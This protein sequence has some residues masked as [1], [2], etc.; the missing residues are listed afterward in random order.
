LHSEQYKKLRQDMESNW[1]PGCGKCKQEEE[2]GV[3][4]LRQKFN[5]K[6]DPALPK[7]KYLEVGFDNICDL[8]CDG[9]WE[10]WSSS[11]WAKKNPQLPA[12]QG[13][14]STDKFTNIPNSINRVVF[15]GGEPLMTNR[16]RKFLESLDSLESLTVEYF[17]NGMHKLQDTDIDLLSKCKQ[18]HFTVSIDAVGTLNDKVRSGSVWSKVLDTLNQIAGKFDYTIHTTVH[19]NNWHGLSD[20]HDFVKAYKKW[21]INVLTFPRGMDI[22]NLDQ[23][24]KSKFLDMLEKFDIP[25][26]HYIKSHLEGVL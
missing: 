14:T 22:V 3:E 11:W 15:L 9:C 1:L 20:M 12:K 24:D 8:T 25:N 13:I 17:T 16:H 6:Y 18:V 21:T 10:E 4:S 23:T 19:K 2:L 5:A 26:S 7:L